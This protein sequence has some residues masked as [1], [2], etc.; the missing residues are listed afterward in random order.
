MKYFTHH[1]KIIY[2]INNTNID[3]V[4]I[5]RKTEIEI[6]SD[7]ISY[8]NVTTDKI[9]PEM[10]SK[11][12]YNNEED[13]WFINITNG[14]FTRQ[15]WHWPMNI[16]KS[17]NISKYMNQYVYSIKTLPDLQQGDIISTPNSTGITFEYV[18]SWNPKFRAI[19][20]ITSNPL[21][22][23][24][25][26]ISFYK[27][28]ETELIP[29]LFLSMGLSGSDGITYSTT[30]SKV[31]NYIDYPIK[32]KKDDRTISPYY[33]V[34]PGNTYID[35]T[36]LSLEG[37]DGFTYTVLNKYNTS[38]LSSEFDYVDSRLAYLDLS[39]NTVRIQ[40]DYNIEG[41]SSLIK[42]QFDI[43]DRKRNY[44]INVI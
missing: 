18:H 14:I 42:A 10:V 33:G 3:L 11:Q 28:T 4:D 23:L 36:T 41:L 34:S 19:T 12:N 32:F 16:T 27:K 1:P 24:N 44:T 9:T 22:Q 17:E 21:F 6:T 38:T 2:N 20:V 31:T 7:N 37:S 40:K 39:I 25:D 35:N 30:I 5:F 26:N 29:I 15:D 43:S 8:I 13:S